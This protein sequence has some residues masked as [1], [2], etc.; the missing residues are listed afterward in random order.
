M[1]RLSDIPDYLLLVGADVAILLFWWKLMALLGDRRMM[2]SAEV[3]STGDTPTE[4]DGHVD[5]S[6]AFGGKWS[7]DSTWRSFPSVVKLTMIIALV[8]SIGILIEGA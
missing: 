2:P 1:I 5:V 3:M 8:V 4:D 6:P 7:Q